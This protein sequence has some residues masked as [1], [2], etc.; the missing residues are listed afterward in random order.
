MLPKWFNIEDIPYDEMWKNDVI[1]LPRILNRET[2]E[3]KFVLDIEGKTKVAEK[4]Q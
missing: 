2:I 3:Y 4:I 1:W